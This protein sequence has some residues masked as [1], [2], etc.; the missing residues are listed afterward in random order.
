MIVSGVGFVFFNLGR[1]RS[2]PI[3]LIFG[4]IMMVYPYF[5]ENVY[6]MLLIA[7]AMCGALYWFNR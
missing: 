1:K 6:W 7:S 4:I 5:V 2:R 3:Y